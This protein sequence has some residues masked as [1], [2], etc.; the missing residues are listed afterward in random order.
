MRYT[1][2]L[3]TA[4]EAARLVRLIGGMNAV[5]NSHGL[6]VEAGFVP[7]VSGCG[8][9]RTQAQTDCTKA[10]ARF[11]HNLLFS[12]QRKAT[13]SVPPPSPHL[14]PVHGAVMRRSVTLLPM[15]FKAK[16]GAVLD[17]GHNKMREFRY[18]VR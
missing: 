15:K 8:L 9:E 2:R 6:G 14:P 13:Q 10:N 16:D 3:L 7:S 5:A 11:P 12:K 17:R 4:D 1:L 18:C